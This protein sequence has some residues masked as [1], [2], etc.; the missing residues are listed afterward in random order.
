MVRRCGHARRPG[1]AYDQHEYIWLIPLLPGIGAAING[2]V[3]IRSFSRKTAGAR[4]VRDD[5]GRAGPVARRVLAAAR[6]C[7]RTRAPTTSILADRGF[8]PFR[9]QLEQRHGRPAFRCRGASGSIRC[10]AMMLLV[11]TGIGTLIHVYSTAYMADEPRGGVARFFCYL[12]LFCF[13]MLML[14]LGNN[15]LVMFVGWEGVGLCSYLLIGYWY[16]KK[17]AVGR[18]QEGVHHQPHRRL[19]LHPRHLP[20]LHDLRHARLP[21]RAGRRGG[22]AGRDGRVRRAV[23]DLPAAVHRRDRQE[24][25]DSA[26]RLAAGRD[27]RSDAGVGADPRGDDGDGGR[28]HGRPQRRAVLA[29]ADGAWR[30]SRS[31]AC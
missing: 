15:F 3:G 19:G 24:R 20:H 30:S 29:R 13:F 8:P 7:R 25:A 26:V 5:G 28:L 11:V 10:P 2:L 21:R 9:W 23:G 6:R 16:E 14:V 12:N 4:R 1:T 27:G 18:R 22:D 31:S 17:S